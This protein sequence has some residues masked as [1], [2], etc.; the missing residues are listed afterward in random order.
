[1][2]RRPGPK[3]DYA[4]RHGVQSDS[5]AGAQADFGL[6]DFDSNEQII[7]LLTIILLTGTFPATHHN[8]RL[9]SLHSA[10]P[11]EGLNRR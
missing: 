7:I 3:A 11:A 6:T 8:G 1:M 4:C 2:Q 10:S 9:H 5:K